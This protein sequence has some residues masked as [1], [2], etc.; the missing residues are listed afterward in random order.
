[1]THSTT[2]NLIRA[3]AQLINHFGLHTDRHGFASPNGTLDFVSA[4]YRADT[5]CTPN[6]FFCIN[7]SDADLTYAL[8]NDRPSV[9]AAIRH[10]SAHLDPDPLPDSNGVIDHIDL[11]GYWVA[12]FGTDRITVSE[13]IGTLLRAADT[14]DALAELPTAV[15]RPRTAA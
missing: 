11:V 5:N 13:A 12:R 1:M 14:A 7:P 10:L 2:G 8:L 4:L 15:P 3:A 6:A 9:M